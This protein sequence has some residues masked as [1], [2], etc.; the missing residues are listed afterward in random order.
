MAGKTEKESTKNDQPKRAFSLT[1]S[2]QSSEAIKLAFDGEHLA[3]NAE[4]LLVF[5]LASKLGRDTLVSERVDLT[6][7]VGG[8]NPTS[9]S[10]T[11]LHGM[12]AGASQIDHVDMLR[13]RA[14]AKV[15]VFSVV[16]PSTHSWPFALTAAR[17]FISGCAKVQPI[18]R[19]APSALFKSPS[20]GVGASGQR[21]RSP[22]TLTLGYQSETTLRKSEAG[23]QHL[24]SGKFTTNGGW[25]ARHSPGPSWRHSS[26]LG[27]CNRL[28]SRALPAT[29]KRARRTRTMRPRNDIPAQILYQPRPHSESET[30]Q[31]HGLTKRH[32]IT[33]QG[34]RRIPRPG[35]V[36]EFRLS[37]TRAHSL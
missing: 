7:R 34:Q 9:E 11:L 31:N 37:G 8:T 33:A 13:A 12:L 32:T 21:A 15:L 3:A 35:C 26:P 18:P 14:P 27:H 22:P 10:L 19:G 24:P 25:L 17:S 5:T 1:Q 20:L 2:Y 28:P 23:M 4:L 16:A 29:P 6:G 36:G 30:T